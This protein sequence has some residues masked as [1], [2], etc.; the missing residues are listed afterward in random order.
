MN[1]KVLEMNYNKHYDLLINR[2]NTRETIDLYTEKHHIIPRCM[3]GN[4]NENNIVKLTPEEHYIAHQLLVKMF[5]TNPGL[6]LAATM[7]AVSS[8]Y[9]DRINNRLYGWLRRK[10]AE[11]MRIN[12]TGI[13]NS[14]YGTCWISNIETR[15]CMKIQ[16]NLI[17]T[18]INAGWIKQRILNWKLYDIQ[19][20][21]I[22][23]T[24]QKKKRK[25]LIPKIQRKCKKCGDFKCQTP[26]I[27]KKGQMI[28]TL[29]KFFGFNKNVIGTNAFYEE[30]NKIKK[31]IYDEYHINMLNTVAIGKKYL[32]SSQRVDSIFKSLEIKHR[33]VKE[34]QDIYFKSKRGI[35]V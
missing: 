19:I 27:C 7:M 31:L 28:N 35:L 10:H 17:N 12:Q 2:A 16:K 30:Y 15:E 5:P 4:N 32:I 1:N 22:R 3:G 20:E 21:K 6:I 13:Y 8:K 9:N 33:T 11:V 34:G 25:K 18:Y 26:T 24:N 29:I 14:Q 23:N